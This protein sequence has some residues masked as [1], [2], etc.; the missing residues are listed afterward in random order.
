MIA[1][2]LI[3]RR[4]MRTVTPVLP[5]ESGLS[6]GLAYTLWLPASGKPRAGVVILHGAGSQKENHYDFARAAIAVGLAAIAFDQRGHGASQGAMD[7]RVLED[8]ASMAAVLRDG[9]GRDG[10]DPL[11][12]VLRGSSMGAYLAILAAPRVRARAVVAVCPASAEG[13]RRGL[14]TDQLGFR[15]DR[16]TSRRQPRSS[17]YRCSCST[18]RATSECRCSTRGSWPR[19]SARRGAG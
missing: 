15:A 8:I 7:G 11:P 5:A 1:R 3:P 2:G 10:P 4:R 14:M 16:T 6:D 9:A 17:R 18:P 19:C 13:L 12:V